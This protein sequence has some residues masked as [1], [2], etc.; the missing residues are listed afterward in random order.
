MR[1]HAQRLSSLVCQYLLRPMVCHVLHLYTGN[2]AFLRPP[3]A[4]SSTCCMYGPTTGI[5]TANPAIVEK[6]SPKSINIPYSSTR[7]PTTG[8]RRSIS[9]IPDANAV[10][11][12]SF[13]RRAKKTAV[14]YRPI[15]SV[16]PKRN[17]I[18]SGII[19]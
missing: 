7:K 3:A 18:C 11:P 15:V 12:F 2:S 9:T 4:L 1:A 10:V 5:A 6:K 17:R 8:Q 14:L 19:N 16:R 13:W